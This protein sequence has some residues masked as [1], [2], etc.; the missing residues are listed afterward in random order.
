VAN[1]EKIAFII[2]PKS[3]TVSKKHIP[4]QVKEILDL[5][6][7]EPIFLFTQEAGHA[8][9]LAHNCVADNIK[10]V[11]AVGGDGTVNEVAQSLIKTDT[12]LG[13]IPCGSGNGLARHL[14]LPLKTEEAISLLNHS[15]VSEIDY[16]TINDRPFFCTCGVGFDAHIGNKFAQSKKRGFYTYVKE[17]I[18]SFFSY[19]PQKYKLKIDGEKSKH[20]AFMITVANS[21]QYG[22]DAY[23]S[24]S[25]D[26]RDGL[27]DVCIL[28]PF[29]KVKAV[30]LG[31]RLFKK[32]I[33]KSP[34]VDVIK[35]KKVNIKRKHKGEVHLDGEPAVMGKKLKVR[36]ENLGLKV[37]VRMN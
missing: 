32:T 31:I 11:I 17:T 24:P 22:N 1:K 2:N 30:G 29:P 13:I 33:D 18:S 16:G 23:I 37:L 12:A 7:Y 3:G 6:K 28:A 9:Q 25:A 19:S 10:K 34:Y 35:C 8:T 21:G 15:S 14:G 20:Q 4:D 26:I 36:I 27:L 5:N